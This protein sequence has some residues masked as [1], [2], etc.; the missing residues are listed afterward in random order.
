MP[1]KLATLLEYPDR[2]LKRFMIAFENVPFDLEE[3]ETL[4]RVL[5]AWLKSGIASPTARE[6]A[7][8]WYKKFESFGVEGDEGSVYISRIFSSAALR[9]WQGL[10]L[11]EWKPPGAAKADV[12]RK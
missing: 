9:R 10:N 8:G 2:D 7:S 4:L 11:D 6:S 12:H 5:T 1:N 3:K